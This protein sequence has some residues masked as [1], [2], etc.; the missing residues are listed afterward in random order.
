MPLYFAREPGPG[1]LLIWNVRNPGSALPRYQLWRGASLIGHFEGD[2]AWRQVIAATKRQP[3][4]DVW[5]R[6]SGAS[7]LLWL[8]GSCDVPDCP[9]LPC[10]PSECPLRD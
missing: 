4:A 3:A 7:W 8:A 1:D 6:E 5:M 9:L 10:I 2:H